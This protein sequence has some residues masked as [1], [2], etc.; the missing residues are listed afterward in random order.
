M[1]IMYVLLFL[2]FHLL[3]IGTAQAAVVH[4]DWKVS[5][6]QFV[7]FDQQTNLDWL[8][9]SATTGKT[10][11]YVTSHLGDEYY[12]WRFPTVTEVRAMAE[13]RLG[14]SLLSP[15][16]TSGSSVTLST[17]QRQTWYEFMG[18][19]HTSASFG[20]VEPSHISGIYG[21]GIFP[22]GS[23]TNILYG[24][25]AKDGHAHTYFIGIYLVRDAVMDVNGPFAVGALALL[26]I[27]SMMRR[28][29][30]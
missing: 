11:S 10:L 18:I 30:L 22:G 2:S 21:V 14:A 20:Y 8:K 9:L 24:E 7:S 19:T 13:T 25:T 29:H 23:F 26:V 3:W 5:G 12:G 17:A 4:K 15:A 28:K 6:D 1:R 16:F 27:V